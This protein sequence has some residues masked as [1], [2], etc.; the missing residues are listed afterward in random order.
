MTALLGRWGPDGVTASSV[1]S[2]IAVLR[3][4]YGNLQAAFRYF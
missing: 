4:M 1:D 2:T 3:S